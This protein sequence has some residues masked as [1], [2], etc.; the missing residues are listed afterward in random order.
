MNAGR[1][2]HLRQAADLALDVVGGR[3]HQVCQLVDHQDDIRQRL[4]VL[5]LAHCKVVGLNVAH[6]C[7][8]EELVAV[9]HLQE[10][11]GQRPH[12]VLDVGDDLAIHVRDA[13]VARQF[14]HFRVDKH[15]AQRLRPMLHQQPGHH[16][17]DADGL[18]RTGCARNQKMRAPW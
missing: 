2:C 13:V 17:V 3:H 15:E 4:H 9:V 16:R 10:Q 18:A 1:T 14:D 7:V 12:D 11:P 6:T 8:A 5:A